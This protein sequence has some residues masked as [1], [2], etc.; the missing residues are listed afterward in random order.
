MEK[1]GMSSVRWQN[2]TLQLSCLLSIPT[3]NVI[4]NNSPHAHK[5]RKLRERLHC[6]GAAQLRCTEDRRVLC[7]PYHS[8][9]GEDREVSSILCLELQTSTE[10]RPPWSQTPSQYPW[11]E[12][13][14]LPSGLDTW[15]I[16]PLGQSQAQDSGLPQSQ[17]SIVTNMTLDHSHGPLPTSQH[18]LAPN[19]GFRSTLVLGWHS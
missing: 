6:L 15:A 16:L 18:Y 14:D 11:T 19:I 12:P 4:L 1:I 13:P 2:R 5:W 17:A 10:E 9:S 8:M 7:Y 3:P